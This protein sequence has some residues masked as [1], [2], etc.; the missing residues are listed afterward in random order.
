MVEIYYSGETQ[1]K[2]IYEVKQNVA[3]ELIKQ[4]GWTYANLVEVKNEEITDTIVED[5][6]EVE[7]KVIET[8]TKKKKY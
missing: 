8:S 7:E 4:E 3:S 6:K 5:I 1:P 2:G